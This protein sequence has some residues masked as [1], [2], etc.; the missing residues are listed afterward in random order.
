MTR[1]VTGAEKTEHTHVEAAFIVCLETAKLVI[2]ESRES[3]LGHC[4]NLANA[5]GGFR[6]KQKTELS[7]AKW[8]QQSRIDGGVRGLGSMHLR[9][10]RGLIYCLLAF[11]GWYCIMGLKAVSSYLS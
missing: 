11:S 5:A 7:T 3:K 9:A 1:F 8:G 4:A 2:A 6:R 10:A